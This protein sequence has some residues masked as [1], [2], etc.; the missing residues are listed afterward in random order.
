MIP[1]FR[2]DFQGLSGV[3]RATAS[4]TIS[5]DTA[6]FNV[7]TAFGSPTSVGDYTLTINM[8]V[9]IYS[10]NTSV[11][12]LTTGVF[13]AG[14]TLTIINNGS[15]IGM[16]GAGG[17]G[18]DGQILNLCCGSPTSQPGSPGLAGGNA[19]S[20][21]M[22]T[23]INNTSGNIFG[24]GN[25]GAGG[26]SSGSPGG[27]RNGPGGGGGGGRSGLTSSAG[28]APG[29]LG[30][31]SSAATAG[32][33]GTTVGPG[34]GGFGS[35]VIWGCNTAFGGDG[36]TGGDYGGGKACALNANTLTFTGGNNGTQV[37]GAVS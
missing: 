7:F 32:G 36:A 30:G 1:G 2:P 25:G 33:A 12:A 14:S 11:A 29:A 5:A 27:S 37:K 26:V 17:K 35:N 31:A 3:G 19:M 22:N 24:G 20:I 10:N 4:L 16:G 18:A 34:A 28:G 23:T 8:G 9:R 6:N 21:G 15:I 13:P